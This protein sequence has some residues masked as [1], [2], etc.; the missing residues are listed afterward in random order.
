MGEDI[1][2]V[3]EEL[4]KSY[5]ALAIAYDQLRPESSHTSH[6]GSSSSSN[7]TVTLCA[8][9]NEKATGDLQGPKLEDAF[10]CHLKSIVRG[11]DMKFDGTDL[12]FGQINKLE[13]EYHELVSAVN[14]SSVM[15]KAGSMQMHSRRR[16]NDRFSPQ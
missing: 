7:T 8:I 16:T 6:S 3:L 14:P 5:R 10:N 15:F 1:T 2:Q 4:S 13:D 11:P 12:N 9:C